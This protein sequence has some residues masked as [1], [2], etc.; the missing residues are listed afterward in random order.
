MLLAREQNVFNTKQTIWY[1]I[2]LS[3]SEIADVV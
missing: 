3:V 2:Q 1:D